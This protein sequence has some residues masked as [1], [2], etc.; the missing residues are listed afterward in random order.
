MNRRR[1]FI[2]VS[3]S[4]VLHGALLAW[5]AGTRVRTP[6]RVGEQTARPVEWVVVEVEARPVPQSVPQPEVPPVV[7]WKRPPLPK[8][9]APVHGPQA[10]HSEPAGTPPKDAPVA[11][12]ARASRLLPSS[13][14]FE[15]P[16]EAAQAGRGQTLYPDDSALSEWAK[17]EEEAFRVHRRVDGWAKD[18]AAGARAQRGLPHPYLA[19]VGRALREGLGAAEGATPEALGAP[20]A[21]EFLARR[22]F[23]AAEQFARTGNPGTAT[24]GLGE[25]Q[26]EKLRQRIGGESPVFPW[27]EAL[28]QSGETMQDLTRGM[29]RLSLT[30]EL[31]QGRD[32]ATLSE[33]VLQS[34]GSVAFD[35]FV[36]RV[37][38]SALAQLGP[39]PAE[40]LRG[41]EELRSVWLI[42][43]WPRLP[44][45]LEE[46]L[47]LLGTPGAMGVPVDALL[48][49][50]H[51]QERF[52]FRARLLRAY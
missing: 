48:Q 29:P 44:R 46:A 23:T 19:G 47:T 27:V 38:P 13:G 35:E 45:K 30:F 36:L 34:S 37:V 26:S 43:G 49:Q 41:N 25:R 5:V 20:G 15:A 50:A 17:R 40:A 31:R 32:G 22:Y 2:T 21:M 28:T 7:R 6:E 14:F 1:L 12:S 11:Q 39:V 42:E 33:K 16:G 8:N 4:L 10:A 52:D 51:A 3:A 24:P 18:T 9:E